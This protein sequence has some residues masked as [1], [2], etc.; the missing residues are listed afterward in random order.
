MLIMPDHEEIPE[1]EVVRRRDE[2]IRRALNTPP[3][4]L[5]EYVGKSERAIAQQKRRIK[6]AVQSKP[7]ST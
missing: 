2:A 5:K 7:K 4:P 1:D 6:K 3:K